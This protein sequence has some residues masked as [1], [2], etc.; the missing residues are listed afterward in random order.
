M[1]GSDRFKTPGVCYFYIYG[2][3]GSWAQQQGLVLVGGDAAIG[4]PYN[5]GGTTNKRTNIGP[6]ELLCKFFDEDNGFRCNPLSC[7]W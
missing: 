1:P 4:H 3:L 5:S 2:V 6:G 7:Q